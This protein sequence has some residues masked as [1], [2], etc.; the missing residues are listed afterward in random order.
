M[1]EQQEDFPLSVWEREAECIFTRACF[2]RK[3]TSAQA[4]QDAKALEHRSPEG[5]AYLRW[6]L[7]RR[8]KLASASVFGLWL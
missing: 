7:E 1:N 3:Y 5:A 8:A 2:G 4:V 6:L